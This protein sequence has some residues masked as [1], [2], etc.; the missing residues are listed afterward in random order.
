MPE[1]TKAA[2]PRYKIRYRFLTYTR[3]YQ[4]VEGRKIISRHDLEAHA[5]KAIERLEATNAQP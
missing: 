1:T 3:E 2:K 5:V 4:V